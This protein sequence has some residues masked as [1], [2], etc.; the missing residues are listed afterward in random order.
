MCIWARI[1]VGKVVW[2][3]L[4]LKT[5]VQLF[6]GKVWWPW[7]TAPLEKLQKRSLHVRGC[8]ENKAIH[9]TSR[10]N[11]K[12]RSME[13]VWPGRRMRSSAKNLTAGSE[14]LFSHTH[15]NSFILTALRWGQ[16]RTNHLCSSI[17]ACM[18]VCICIYTAF[19]FPRS[20][21]FGGTVSLIRSSE[22]WKQLYFSSLLLSSL[23]LHPSVPLSSHS[24]FNLSHSLSPFRFF[25]FPLCTSS[26]DTH[27][28]PSRTHLCIAQPSSVCRCDC[29][30]VLVCTCV[31]CPVVSGETTAKLAQFVKSREVWALRTTTLL[32]SR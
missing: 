9:R 16:V 29:V 28:Q 17:S 22:L 12:L 6:S 15:Y 11:R 25:F 32:S 13:K 18:W 27:E 5:A 23:S 26:A 2:E 7:W 21:W 8:P 20:I 24:L 4:T 31:F 3:I 14:L 30:Y 1:W 10:W 19:H